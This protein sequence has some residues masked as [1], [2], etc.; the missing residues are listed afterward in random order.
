MS[1]CV[2]NDS[3]VLKEKYNLNYNQRRML[4]YGVCI[5]VRLGLVYLSYKMY[6][7]KWFLY[8]ALIVSGIALLRNANRVNKDDCVWW[9]RLFHYVNL[10]VILSVSIIQLTTGDRKPII[11]IL[12]LIDVLFGILYSFF[13]FNN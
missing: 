13:N 6:N 1:K 8:V 3:G 7:T 4:F 10:W 12:L 9:S 2:Q 5:W 11:S